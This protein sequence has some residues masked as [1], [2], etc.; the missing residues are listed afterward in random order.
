MDKGKDSA[1]VEVV[2]D[3]LEPGKTLICT[4]RTVLIL[5]KYLCVT[6]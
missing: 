1:M 4:Q 3:E 5:R 6:Q 2:A